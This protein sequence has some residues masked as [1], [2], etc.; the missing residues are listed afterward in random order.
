MYAGCNISNAYSAAG[1][2]SDLPPGCTTAQYLVGLQSGGLV[3][4]A[5]RVLVVDINIYS[6][7][8]GLLGL[9]RVTF[10]QLASGRATFQPTS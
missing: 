3:D 4:A 6:P 2:G 10:E 7:E 9:V 5:T 1:D 8:I